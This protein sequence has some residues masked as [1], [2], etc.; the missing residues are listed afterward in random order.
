ML[1]HAPST[2]VVVAADADDFAGCGSQAAPCGTI[3]FAVV[4]IAASIVPVDAVVTIIV[5]MGQYDHRSC[6]AVAWRPLAIQ[7][8]GSS[9]TTVDCGGS[10]RLLFS[11][12]SVAVGGVTVR[13]GAVTVLA[14]GDGD[15]GS[16]YGGGAVSVAWPGVG[17]S[18]LSAVFRDV[19]FIDNVV[20]VMGTQG[21]VY[22]GGGAVAVFSLGSAS[23]SRV[24]F[25]GC[26]FERNRVVC[27][28]AGACTATGG[29]AFVTFLAL[30]ADSLDDNAVQF[31]NVTV[32]DNVSGTACVCGG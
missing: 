32:Q 28:G 7:G 14:P 20:E 5:T 11:N 16:E 8:A 27:G 18:A 25:D 23:H 15:V 4:V 21:G 3:Q 24:T 9:V 1:G 19:R 12:S 31:S 30:G 26:A 6:G 13:N 10:G 2:T 22:T 17:H 29:A